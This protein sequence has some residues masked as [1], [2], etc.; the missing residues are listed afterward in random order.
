[1]FRILTDFLGRNRGIAHVAVQMV[2]TLDSTTEEQRTRMCE[3]LTRYFGKLE[4]HVYIG[5]TE[6]FIQE[7]SQRWEEYER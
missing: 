6:T 2:P 5:R 4:I 3:F 7:L 1:M